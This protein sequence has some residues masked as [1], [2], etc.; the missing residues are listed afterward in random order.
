MEM[1]PREKHATKDK[2]GIPMGYSQCMWRGKCA[3]VFLGRPGLSAQ[4][5]ERGFPRK[6]GFRASKG[7]VEMFLDQGMELIGH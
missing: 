3:T 5:P 6:N 7:G 4:K 1:S 2:Y